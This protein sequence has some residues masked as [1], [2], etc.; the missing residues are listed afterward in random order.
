LNGKAVWAPVF[1]V[2]PATIFHHQQRQ[3]FPALTT[4]LGPL[5]AQR[6]TSLYDLMDSANDVPQIQAF[7]RALGHAP[8]ELPI[9]MISIGTSRNGDRTQ[10][11]PSSQRINFPN[12]F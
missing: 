5:T 8:K 3:L 6:M 12:V 2:Q 4:G 7:S 1:H 10:R 9:G 11:P